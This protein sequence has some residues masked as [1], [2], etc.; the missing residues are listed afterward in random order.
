MRLCILKRIGK[1]ATAE[2]EAFASVEQHVDSD[3]PATFIWCSDDDNVV[4]PDNTR[5]M[6][7][8]LGAAHVPVE[9]TIYHG[10]MHGAGP[11]TGTA[12]EGW[13][14]RAVAFWKKQGE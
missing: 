6:I 11:A 7:E 1:N 10:V 2:R 5:R 12:A 4:N 14:N 3:Y 8:A 9:S 13:I